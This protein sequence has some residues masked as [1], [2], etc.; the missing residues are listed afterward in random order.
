MPDVFHMNIED[1]S[2]EGSLA[3]HLDHIGYIHFADSNRHA[4]GSGHLNFPNIVM[5]LR[6]LGYSGYVTAEI[7][8]YP[9]PD[10]AA[11]R[12]A[13]YLRALIPK[14]PDSSTS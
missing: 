9:T 3:A 11:A 14:D 1:A 4:P 7:L 2:I 12:A 13:A 5:L 8:P 10:E 6:S